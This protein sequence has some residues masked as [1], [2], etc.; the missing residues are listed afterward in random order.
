M[1]I[2]K[3]Y[4]LVFKLDTDKFCISGYRCFS[5]NHI[6]LVFCESFMEE[7]GTGC[8]L[9]MCL[10]HSYGILVRTKSSGMFLTQCMYYA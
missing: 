5:N 6:K 8:H 3:L 1:L 4:L 7:L 2:I 9:Y 10:I